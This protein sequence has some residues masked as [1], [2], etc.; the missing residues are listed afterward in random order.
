MRVIEDMS[1]RDFTF[2]V[3]LVVVR[4]PADHMLA[5]INGDSTVVRGNPIRNTIARLSSLSTTQQIAL[6]LL[7]TAGTTVAIIEGVDDGS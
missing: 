6:G 7:V 3:A 5:V 4:S 2:E 1:R